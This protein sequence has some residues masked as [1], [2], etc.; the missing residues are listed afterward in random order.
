MPAESANETS[1]P[2]QQNVRAA[3]KIFLLQAT[4]YRVH[5]SPLPESGPPR[6]MLT[7]PLTV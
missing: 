1:V 4:G 6:V 5:Y 3:P 2:P 7:P